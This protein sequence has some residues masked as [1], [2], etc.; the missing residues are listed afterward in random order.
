MGSAVGFGLVSACS[1]VCICYAEEEGYDAGCRMRVS[2]GY[3]VH[4]V[5]V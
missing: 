1:A 4:L 2:D 3:F 5:V